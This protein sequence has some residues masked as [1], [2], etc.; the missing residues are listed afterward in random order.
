MSTPKTAPIDP[1]TGICIA[2]GILCCDMCAPR[3]GALGVPM[4]NGEQ[5]QE[6]RDFQAGWDDFITR[7]GFPDS[8]R[9]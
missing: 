8:L 2:H 9:G 1:E 4:T 5:I 6:L 7:H 3:L